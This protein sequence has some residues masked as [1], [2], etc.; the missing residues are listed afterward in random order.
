[1]FA[2]TAEKTC[3]SICS[4]HVSVVINVLYEMKCVKP[5]K[6]VTNKC[7]SCVCVCVCVCV[8]ELA[9]KK[10]GIYTYK[11]AV[12]MHKADCSVPKLDHSR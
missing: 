1:M 6:A 4:L 10:G 7:M 12:V 9:T 8:G 5:K 11:L 2:W 3:H